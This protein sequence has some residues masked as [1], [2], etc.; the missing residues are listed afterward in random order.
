MEVVVTTAAIRR[1]KLQSQCHHQQTNTLVFL[2]AGCPSCRPTNSVKALKEYKK[3]GSLKRN[4]LWK[5]RTMYGL[6]WTGS[7]HQKVALSGWLECNLFTG[8][9]T[10]PLPMNRRQGIEDVVFFAASCSSKIYRV[11]APILLVRQQKGFQ[12]N[13]QSRFSNSQRFLL[14]M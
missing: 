12:A 1:A 11:C 3:V 14:H 9:M 7:G 5:G 8:W 2:Q 10:T 4:P 6:R 13:R